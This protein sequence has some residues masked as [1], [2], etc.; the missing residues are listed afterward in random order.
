MSCEYLWVD[1]PVGNLQLIA[2]GPALAGIL[3]EVERANR[4]LLGPL[5][6]NP[7]NA[8]LQQTAQQLAEYFDGRRERFDIPLDFTGTADQHAGRV[9]ACNSISESSMEETS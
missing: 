8:V 4:V 7:R 1:S 9:A 2:R 5:V 3:W 6:E